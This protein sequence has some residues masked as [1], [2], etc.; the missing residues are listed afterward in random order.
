LNFSA[1]TTS[2]GV[3]EI[4]ESYFSK[5]AKSKW[6]PKNSKSKALCFIDDLNMPRIDTFGS[7]PPLELVRQFMTY[8]YWYD[9]STVQKNE[10]LEL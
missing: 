8:G 3:Q 9:R 2:N 1:G 6:K 10:I 4:I 5:G 7:Q